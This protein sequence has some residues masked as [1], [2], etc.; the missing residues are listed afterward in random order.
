MPL[1]KHVLPDVSWQLLVGCEIGAYGLK[2]IIDWAAKALASEND[3]SR[4]CVLTDLVLLRQ[5]R[6]VDSAV[7]NSL[8]RLVEL[9]FP[10]FELTDP[11]SKHF[12]KEL[13][14]DCLR[15]YVM[16]QG[17]PDDICGMVGKIEVNFDYPD[18]LGRMYDVCDW[19]PNDRQKTPEIL[20]EAEAVLAK[21]DVNGGKV[22]QPT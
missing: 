5:K 19:V 2:I 16:G 11:A 6:D 13:W 8:R 9:E 7:I 10:K 22:G 12:A 15:Q 17:Q 14:F 4:W 20:R 1:A 3:Q 21:F 18:W